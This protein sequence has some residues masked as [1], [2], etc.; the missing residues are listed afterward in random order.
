MLADAAVHVSR[1]QTYTDLRLDVSITRGGQ[2]GTNQESSVSLINMIW[3]LISS[4]LHSMRHAN[5]LHLEG[6]RSCLTHQNGLTNT[7]CGPVFT[8]Y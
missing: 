4:S 8:G 5:Y 1:W 6:P 2:R 7:I 3:T